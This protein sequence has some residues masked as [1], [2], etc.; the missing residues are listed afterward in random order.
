MG[1]FSPQENLHTLAHV[2]SNGMLGDPFEVTQGVGQGKIL[3]THCYK[4]IELC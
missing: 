3:S 2:R 4:A 1:M